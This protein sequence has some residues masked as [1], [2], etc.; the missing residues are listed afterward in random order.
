MSYRNKLI[1]QESFGLKYGIKN[2][3]QYSFPK[4]YKT[5]IGNSDIVR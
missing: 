5:Y 4:I 3:I 1:T 2:T